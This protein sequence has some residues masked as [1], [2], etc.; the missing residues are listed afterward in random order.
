M[1]I[2]ICMLHLLVD[3]NM[4]LAFIWQIKI[5]CL[6]NITIVKMLKS[7]LLFQIKVE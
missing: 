6:V 2:N 4:R 3:M 7:S 1:E 5:L